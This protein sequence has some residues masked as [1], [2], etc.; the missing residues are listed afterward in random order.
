MC[1]FT[2]RDAADNFVNTAARH[3]AS[4]T[5]WAKLESQ[6]VLLA[7]LHNLAK[8]SPMLI[9]Y[10]TQTYQHKGDIYISTFFMFVG[11]LYR[12]KGEGSSE[13]RKITG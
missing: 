1:V 7:S 8:L 4:A 11:L 10:Q 12:R 2:K 3:Q 13:G 6:L 5:L 9:L